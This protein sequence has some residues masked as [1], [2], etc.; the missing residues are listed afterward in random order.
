MGY[1]LGEILSNKVGFGGGV[2]YARSINMT[3]ESFIEEEFIPL[4]NK[5]TFL[6]KS[7]IHPLNDLSDMLERVKDLTSNS[8]EDKAYN[9]DSLDDSIAEYVIVQLEEMRQEIGILLIDIRDVGEEEI[10]EDSFKEIAEPLINA[11]N[12]LNDV[13]SVITSNTSQAE[14]PT[15][16]G[17]KIN[18][19]SYGVQ[20]MLQ[21]CMEQIKL[22]EGPHT[23]RM[24]Q[25]EM[26][27]Q[28]ESFVENWLE[29][30]GYI[31]PRT[32]PFQEQLVRDLIRKEIIK[33]VG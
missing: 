4:G 19:T 6:S 5:L 3:L 8:S 16:L 14:D 21:R 29:E 24:L 11:I 28:N 15:S 26:S 30:H 2:D 20:D 10:N 13:L 23:Y 32:T 31:E 18:E 17:F 22:E 33:V 9:L 25:T 7:F 12:T 1:K 27:K